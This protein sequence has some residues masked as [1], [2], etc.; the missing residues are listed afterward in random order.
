[1]YQSVSVKVTLPCELLST[2]VAFVGFLT[3]VIDLVHFETIVV[4]E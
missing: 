2:L 3:R 4:V 1:M